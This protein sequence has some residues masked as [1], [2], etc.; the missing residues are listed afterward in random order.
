MKKFL[1]TL[2]FAVVAFSLGSTVISHAATAP[3]KREKGLI[4]KYVKA[5]ER[6][7]DA[8][9]GRLTYPKRKIVMNNGFSGSNVK[10]FGA[11]YSMKYD[12]K[13]K[14]N[15]L[16]SK[17]TV[18]VSNLNSVKVYTGDISVYIKKYKKVSYLHTPK[19]INLKPVDFNKLDF[20]LVD[21]IKVY[22]NGKYGFETTSK[23][24]IGNNI[25]SQA[26]ASNPVKLGQTYF[27][28]SSYSYNQY[29]VMGRYA[30]T[31]N[32][33]EDATYAEAVKF[34]YKFE[35][36]DTRKFKRVNL[37]WRVLDAQITKG[38]S[39]IYDCVG[40]FKPLIKG[41]EIVDYDYINC[42]LE[43]DLLNNIK[44][45]SG[46]A[47]NGKPSETTQF[48]SRGDVILPVIAD[49]NNGENFM[50]VEKHDLGS[51]EK[52]YFKIQ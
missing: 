52:L 46:K 29:G 20:K 47:S 30:L 32:S 24:I 15:L 34:G 48:E 2:V 38:S 22:L 36:R 1:K 3:G 19:A 41:S 18:V 51:V 4:Q 23:L 21:K 26:T 50:V 14:M 13:K 10:T 9:L 44:Y 35:E 25:A 11:T 45:R 8:E 17:C 27:F 5:F 12:S 39:N 40:L 7:D 43:K 28:D 31:V 49:G 33:V 6:N 42:S 37:T 16:T